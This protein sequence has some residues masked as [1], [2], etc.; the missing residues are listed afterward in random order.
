MEGLPR[1][2]L[3][4]DVVEFIQ[5]LDFQDV[6]KTE[7]GQ[8]RHGN[9]WTVRAKRQDQCELVQGT[10]MDDDGEYDI[11]II[12][13]VRRRVDKS[14]RVPL[15]T[16]RLRF[17]DAMKLKPSAKKPAGRGP[18]PAAKPEEGRQGDST[19]AEAAEQKSARK[20]QTSEGGGTGGK[21]DERSRSPP[22]SK[23]A[24]VAG[25]DMGGKTIKNAADGNCLSHAMLWLPSSPSKGIRKGRIAN[26][27]LSCLLTSR[28]TFWPMANAGMM[29]RITW[30]RTLLRTL[31]GTSMSW[32]S[33]KLGVASLNCRS[34]VSLLMSRHWLSLAGAKLGQQMVMQLYFE[35]NPGHRKLVEGADP[36]AWRQQK[37][38]LEVSPHKWILPSAGASACV[39]ECGP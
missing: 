39:E 15:R 7:T 32:P 3:V 34:S 29:A 22:P 26:C 33:L 38:E 35:Y 5:S 2:F 18:P 27:V 25:W 1:G 13:A 21:R 23:D 37:R 16:D 6:E 9:A 20:A 28:A 24:S 14:K 4:Y 36:D 10:V 31:L 12:K 19:A 30:G 11:T 17:G 8:R